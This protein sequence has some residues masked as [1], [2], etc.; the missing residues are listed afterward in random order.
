MSKLKLKYPILFLVAVLVQVLFMDNIQF[1]RFVNPYFYILF[2]LLL[3]IGIPKYLLLL[4]G[5]GLGMVFWCSCGSNRFNC[6]YK[7]IF[8]EYLKSRRSRESNNSNNIEYRFFNFCQICCN[9]HTYP[10]FFSFLS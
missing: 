9:N 7:T 1:S 3:P 6:I 8:I 10:S 5:F 2:I 4:L